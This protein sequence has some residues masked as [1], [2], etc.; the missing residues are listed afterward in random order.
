MGTEPPP[1]VGREGDGKAAREGAGRTRAGVDAG[2]VGGTARSAGGTA[3]VAV[4]AARSTP[5]MRVGNRRLVVG[6]WVMALGLTVGA[7]LRLR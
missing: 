1:V 3:A 7:G 5:A 6:R 4:Q 2:A